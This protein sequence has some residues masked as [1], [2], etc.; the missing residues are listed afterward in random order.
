M[1]A[2]SLI[3]TENVERFASRRSSVDTRA[4][5]LNWMGIRAVSAG[6][7]QPTWTMIC[8][9]AIA[10]MYVLFPLMFWPVMIWKRVSSVAK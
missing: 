4:K 7:K 6:M 5:R 9:I 8:S 3:S 1:N 2:I 10:R